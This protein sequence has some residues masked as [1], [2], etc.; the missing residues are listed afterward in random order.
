MRWVRGIGLWDQALGGG[1]WRVE[2]GESV[3]GRLGHG[4]RSPG[5]EPQ[6]VTFLDVEQNCQPKQNLIFSVMQ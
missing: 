6:P 1:S 4:V 3:G 5:F 2:V